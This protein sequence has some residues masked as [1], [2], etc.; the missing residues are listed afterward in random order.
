[1]EPPAPTTESLG[2]AWRRGAGDAYHGEGDALD[3]LC[4]ELLDRLL[5]LAKVD[6]GTDEQNRC[7]GAVVA[8]LGIPLH[9]T[10]HGA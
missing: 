4:R 1:M 2:G 10:S 8:D 9:S 5:V 3:A 6:L 7:R